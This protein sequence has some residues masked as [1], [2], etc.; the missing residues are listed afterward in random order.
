MARHSSSA[1]PISGDTKLNGTERFLY[2]G[3]ALLERWT[4]AL[5]SLPGSVE[6]YEPQLDI[7]RLRELF[8]DAVDNGSPTRVLCFD[9]IATM[10]PSLFSTAPHVVDLGCGSGVYSRHLKNVVSYQSYLG[11]DAQQSSHWQK[12]AD[13]EVSFRKQEIGKN[14]ISIGEA[15]CIFS[16]SVLEHIRYDRS[17]LLNLESEASKPLTHLHFVPAPPSFFEHRYHGY[18]RY[19]AL[20]IERLLTGI[21][22]S[23]I[24]IW[25]LGNNITREFY[26]GQRRKPKKFSSREGEII[27][28]ASM[29]MVENLKAVR[30]YIIPR[31]F[32][33]ASFFA[34]YFKQ[35]LQGATAE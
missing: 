5:G 3:N 25:P 26:W 30:E 11:L 24:R 34:I 19:G 28:N 33:E 32:R 29:S 20:Q 22:A 35:D 17:A 18:R 6:T 7:A 4:E 1:S 31:H 8:G 27:F 10:M 13:A 12:Y 14:R 16:Q 9:F 15:D 21:G 23:D 2:R